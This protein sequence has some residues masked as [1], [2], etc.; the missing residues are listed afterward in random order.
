MFLCDI[1]DQKLRNS[2]IP[3]KIDLF[4]LNIRDFLQTRIRRPYEITEI[5][6]PF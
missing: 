5:L 3:R 2:I 1:F 4:D 6:S